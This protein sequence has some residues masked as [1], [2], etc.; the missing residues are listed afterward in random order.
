MC[1]LTLDFICTYK[2]IQVDE[3]EPNELGISELLYN[4]QYLQTFGLTEFQEDVINYKLDVIY[5]KMKDEPF[6]QEL[7]ENHPYKESM[8]NEVMF[9]T[10]FSYDYLDITHK[11]LQRYYNGLSVDESITALKAKLLEK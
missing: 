1:D 4:I 2:L 11:L 8:T 3:S 5:D 6:M 9:R 7:F 10:L